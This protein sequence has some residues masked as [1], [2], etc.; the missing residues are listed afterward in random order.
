MRTTPIN[1]EKIKRLLPTMT[2]SD[3]E[4]YE[5]HIDE[6]H[7]KPDKVD[8]LDIVLREQKRAQSWFRSTRTDFDNKQY[9]EY[10]TVMA[11]TT[12]MPT[13]IEWMRDARNGE[14]LELTYESANPIR[15]GFYCN[16]I[17]QIH[18]YKSNSM[19]I[20]IKR[21]DAMKFGFNVI[22]AFPKLQVRSREKN[23]SGF[24]KLNNADKNI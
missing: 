11:L 24:N 19:A 14:H 5:T 15:N 23:E 22:T 13:I 21:N 1:E 10:L 20:Y 17:N 9:A 6:R 8:S 16:K 4:N 2:F 12:N 3:V 7:V 18:E